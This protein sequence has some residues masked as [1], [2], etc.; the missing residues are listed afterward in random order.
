MMFYVNS[1]IIIMYYDSD[2]INDTLKLDVCD[3]ISDMVAEKCSEWGD[4][5][6]HER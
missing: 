2:D 5:T 6:M 3:I 4:G 1:Y